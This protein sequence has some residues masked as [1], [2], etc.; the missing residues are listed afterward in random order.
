MKLAEIIK[1]VTS[2]FIPDI[3]L[4]LPIHFNGIDQPPLTNL[5]F[6]GA[7]LIPSAQTPI[8]LTGTTPTIQ[9]VQG[10]KKLFEI[11]LSGNTT[12]S[13]VGF[14]PGDVFLVRAKQGSGTSYTTTWFAGVT[15]VRSG[16]TA[17]TQTTTSNGVEEYGFICR[18]VGAYDGFVVA[19]Q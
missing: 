9:P 19:S 5:D 2:P 1:V 16:G 13:I 12:F 8:T 18:A 10:R 6:Q 15:W 7:V 17:P 4:P 11:V 14:V 3:D